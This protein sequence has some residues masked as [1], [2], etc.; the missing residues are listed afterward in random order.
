MIRVRLPFEKHN[1]IKNSI[2]IGNFSKHH[3]QNF[4]T[5]VPPNVNDIFDDVVASS[6]QQVLITMTQFPKSFPDG[7]IVIRVN[8]QLHACNRKVDM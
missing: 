4:N 5:A 6:T 7:T 2:N 8:E 3:L 1:F